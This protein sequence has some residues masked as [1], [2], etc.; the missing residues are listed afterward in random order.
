MVEG[1]GKGLIPDDLMRSRMDHL[2]FEKEE[3]G[4]RVREL[5]RQLTALELTE[6]QEAQ[7]LAFAERVRSGLGNLS[8]A[9]KQELFR[10][11]VEDVTCYEDKAVIRTIIPVPPSPPSEEKLHL[12]TRPGQCAY[13]HSLVSYKA[14]TPERLPSI[15]SCSI[16]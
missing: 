5:E 11:L 3:L 8:F 6:E 16:V 9:E 1:Y 2:K 12:Y 7:A 14:V 10:L 15:F 13:Q 4:H